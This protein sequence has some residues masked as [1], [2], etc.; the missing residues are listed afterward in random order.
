MV[1]ARKRFH[2]SPVR[3]SEEAFCLLDNLSQGQRQLI[4]HHLSTIRDAGL[5]D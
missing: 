1:A 2:I 4:A 3:W 5:K